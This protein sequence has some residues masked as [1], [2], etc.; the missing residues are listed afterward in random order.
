MED[1]IVDFPHGCVQVDDKLVKTGCK[2]GDSG[3]STEASMSS[4][5]RLLHSNSVGNGVKSRSLVNPP[6]SG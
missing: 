6:L 5:V 3:D 1:H 2:G 4:V